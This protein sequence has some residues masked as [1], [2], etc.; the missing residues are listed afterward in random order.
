MEINIRYLVPGI[1]TV[2]IPEEILKKSKEEIRNW[3]L[4]ALAEKTNK[5]LL[6]GL[7]TVAY[8]GEPIE[9]RIFDEVRLVEAIEKKKL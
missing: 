8:N 9:N 5:E 3:A 2:D 7:E 6:E 1:I 4:D